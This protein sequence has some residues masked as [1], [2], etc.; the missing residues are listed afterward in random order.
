MFVPNQAREASMNASQ[1]IAGA[2]SSAAQRFEEALSLH[3]QGS[4]REA[5]RLYRAILASD[6][7]TSVLLSISA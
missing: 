3:R 4:L 6:A 2:G 7:S 1:P 5:A